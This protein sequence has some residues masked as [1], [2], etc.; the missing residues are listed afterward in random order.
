M[1]AGEPCRKWGNIMYLIVEDSYG[2][3]SLLRIVFNIG[4]TCSQYKM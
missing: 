1:S 3:H 2:V 4:L